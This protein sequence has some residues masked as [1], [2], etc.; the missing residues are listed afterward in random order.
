MQVLWARGPATAR[1]IT[2][3]LNRTAP[4]AHSTVQTLLRKLEDKGAVAHD[5]S[6]RTFIFRPLAKPEQV[7]Q[8]ATREFVDRLFGGSPG[9]LVA[10]LLRNERIPQEELDEIRRL[11][12]GPGDS[13]DEQPEAT[14]SS[15]EEGE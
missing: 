13:P 11:L 14:G 7:C 2:D 4:I 9:G 6:E 10:Y 15:E 12:H 5:V 1:E 3:A 8:R